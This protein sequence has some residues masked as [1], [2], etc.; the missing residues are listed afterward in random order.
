LRRLDSALAAGL[1]SRD[2]RS[3]GSLDQHVARVFESACRDHAALLARDGKF[4]SDMILGRWW[5]DETVE[6]DVLGISGDN[7][8]ML[9]ECRWQK[10][11]LT[12]RDVLELQRKI[13]FVP[14]P[15][16]K[17][18]LLFWTRTGAVEPGFPTRVYSVADVI[19]GG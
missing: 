12:M 17:V 9:G 13:S 7:T 8:G 18:L 1:A 5:R 11:P 3:S 14:A 19:N 6:I 15:A 4:A 10:A 2:E 16:A